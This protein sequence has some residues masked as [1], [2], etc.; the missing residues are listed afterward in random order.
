MPRHARRPP[1]RRR[2]VDRALG[3]SRRRRQLAYVTIATGFRLLR[4]ALQRTVFTAGAAAA[5]AVLL[6]RF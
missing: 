6:T 4:P 1:R 5:A 3:V 2:L